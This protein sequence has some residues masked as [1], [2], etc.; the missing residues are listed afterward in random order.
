M[1]RSA[2]TVVGSIMPTRTQLALRKAVLLPQHAQEVP[3]AAGDAVR[4]DAPLQQAL[5][6]AV[7]VAN[8]ITQ[9]AAERKID[10]MAERGRAAV[11][12]FPPRCH[13]VPLDRP[14]LTRVVL[15]E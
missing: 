5:E 6:R 10:G 8:E 15:V 13:A 3:L 12:G 11:V 14:A 1:P 4:R 2:M 7:G 9:A